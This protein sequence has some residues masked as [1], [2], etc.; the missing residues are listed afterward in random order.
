M[1]AHA[2]SGDREKSLAA[3]M[4]DHITKPIDPKALFASLV[5]WILPEKRGAFTVPPPPGGESEGASASAGA[6]PTAVHDALAPVLGISIADG[7]ARVGGN[8]ALYRKLL[9][10]FYQEYRPIAERITSTLASEDPD[11][12]RHLLH[13]LKGVAGNV[14]ATELYKA[15][16]ALETALA[17]ADP[18]GIAKQGRRFDSALSTV[19]GGLSAWLS[20][21]EPAGGGP[22]AGPTPADDA[23]EE[24]RSEGVDRA[25]FKRL[26]S[27]MQPYL[28]K[29]EL[30]QLKT[31]MAQINRL[32]W[33]DVLP[34]EIANLGRL[35]ER[36]R[37]REAAAIVD[38]LLASD[39]G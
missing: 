4:D 16:G 9:K 35:I 14:G 23:R 10:N 8:E 19:L 38:T 15:A 25:V 20:E 13:T 30:I 2:M 32:P 34:P 33:P 17:Q 5:K 36:Y 3:G 37:F 7:L 21:A 27:E 22:G 1:T 31:L 6:G 26:L 18:E 11:S 24:E 29:G 39:G 28:L 12:G